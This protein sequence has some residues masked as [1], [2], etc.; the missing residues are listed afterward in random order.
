MKVNIIVIFEYFFIFLLLNLWV[1]RSLSDRLLFLY[2]VLLLL[3]TAVAAIILIFLRCT[4]CKT[5]RFNSM[6][7]IVYT[8][9]NEIPLI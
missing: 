8:N 6:G 1:C 4:S 3:F 2:S 7:K 9:K 5:N